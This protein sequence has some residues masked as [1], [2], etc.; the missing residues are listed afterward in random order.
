MDFIAI[1]GENRSPVT[2]VSTEQNLF[3]G[4]DGVNFFEG[5]WFVD[6]FTATPKA[7]PEPGT[8]ALLGLGL[9]GV[10][11]ARRRKKV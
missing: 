11:F 4:D 10:G 3:F 7:V 1:M 5:T 8:L 2:F 6:T 9:A